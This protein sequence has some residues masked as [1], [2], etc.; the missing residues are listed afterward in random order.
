MILALSVFTGFLVALMIQFNGILQSATGGYVALLSI[1]LSGLAATMVL[2]PFFRKRFAGDKSQRAPWYCLGAGA[3]GTLIVYIPSLIFAK[4]GILLS[5]SGAL[6][7]QTLAASIAESF[8]STG[9]ERS[10]LIQRIL[11]PALLLPGSIII[12]LKVGASLIWIMLSWTP[13]IILMVQ[14]SMNARNTAYYGTPKTV[15][16]NYITALII[17][18][19]L[20]FI[21]SAAWAGKTSAVL[22][23]LPWYII[24]GGGF[25]GVF[26]TG[27]IAIML[28]KAPALLVILGI[29]TG[30]LAGGIMLDLLNG[31]PVAIEKMIGIA[32]IIAGLGAGKIN[33]NGFKKL[34]RG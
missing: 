17:I 10:P 5:L 28:L 30:E 15:L 3:V 13:G 26:T 24:A 31:N 32:L 1:H 16:F 12:G 29:Y 33:I 20:F 11:S 21:N 18:I 9:R 25:I 6:A 8:Y 22:S 34:K 27:V 19:P 23:E 7:G 2:F 4:G 14:Q